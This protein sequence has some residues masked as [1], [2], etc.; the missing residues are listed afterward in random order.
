MKTYINQFGEEVTKWVNN[1]HPDNPQ[2]MQ[3][4]YW[5]IWVRKDGS[6]L[7]GYKLDGNGKMT[8][9]YGLTKEE[10]IEKYYK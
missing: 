5:K 7:V 4:V 6:T 8:F 9:I 1:I 3:N 10:A 2:F